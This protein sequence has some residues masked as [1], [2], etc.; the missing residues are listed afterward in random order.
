MADKIKQPDVDESRVLLLFN[1]ENKPE[2]VDN[3]E[4]KCYNY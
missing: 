1:F 2:I 4:K 3:G